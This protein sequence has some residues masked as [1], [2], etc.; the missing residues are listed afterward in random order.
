MV[1]SRIRTYVQDMKTTLYILLMPLGL[2]AQIMDLPRVDNKICYTE[3]ITVDSTS[4]EALYYRSREWF[5][6]TYN[7]SKD[8][9]Q[10]DD[11]ESG[12]IIGKANIPMYYT[13]LG[14]TSQN[15]YMNYTISIYLK[16]NRYKY[17]ITNFI[18]DRGIGGSESIEHIYENGDYQSNRAIK[19]YNDYFQQVDTR[20]NG[21]I[22]SLKS[23]MNDRSLIQKR[24]E[25]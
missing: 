23:A 19:L 14:S 20:I 4:R 8:V 3:V 15:G 9:L 13:F 22:E 10:M 7:S 2:M 24:D 12:N 21:I 16:D 25:W 5:A 11:K 6:K 18:F 1:N 17:E